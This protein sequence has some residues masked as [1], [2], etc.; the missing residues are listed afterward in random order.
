MAKAK[1]KKN[2]DREERIAMEIIV[3]NPISNQQNPDRAMLEN[4]LVP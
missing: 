1:Q 3:Y 2:K 4:R